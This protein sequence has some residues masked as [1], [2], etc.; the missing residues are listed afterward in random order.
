MH[1]L[2]G[3]RGLPGGLA[4]GMKWIQRWGSGGAWKEEVGT[5]GD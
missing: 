3:L 1:Y 2:A 4:A 5:V